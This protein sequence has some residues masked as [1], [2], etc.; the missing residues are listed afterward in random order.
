MVAGA[1]WLASCG[2]DASTGG[3]GGVECLSELNLDCDIAIQPTFDGFYESQLRSTCSA[4]GGTCHGPEGASGGLVLSDPDDAYDYLL[5]R[6]DGRARVLPG[7][8]ECSIL[9]QRLES[10]D[11]DFVM[12]VRNQLDEGVRCAVRQWV[13]NG[14]QR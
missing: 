14:A 11:P 2:D 4:G 3:D 8:P 12:P 13:A 9:I 7:N 10:D 5:G 1:L 6:M